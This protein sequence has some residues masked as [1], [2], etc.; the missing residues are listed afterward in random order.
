MEHFS[1]NIDYDDKGVVEQFNRAIKKCP[2]AA[3]RAA[4]RALNAAQTSI[5]KSISKRYALTQKEIKGGASINMYNTDQTSK[6]VITGRL[7]TIWHHYHPSPKYRKT[8]GN[9]HQARIGLKFRRRTYTKRTTSNSRVSV[10]VIRGQR[11]KIG[12]FHRPFPPVQNA[13]EKNMQVFARMGKARRPLKVI[14][15]ISVPQMLNDET[16]KPVGKV[17]LDTLEKRLPVELEYEFNKA[18]KGG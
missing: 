9:H 5:A 8:K 6:I 14:K 4:V 7:L 16:F 10:M 15:G 3:K 1:I 11:R 12:T 17:I 2:V 13:S 18:K